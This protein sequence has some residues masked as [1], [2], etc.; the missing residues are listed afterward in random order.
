LESDPYQTNRSQTVTI[1]RSTPVNITVERAPF[2]CEGNIKNAKVIDFAGG[3]ALRIECER[4]GTWLL[5]E[6]SAANRG[7]RFAVFSRFITMPER[8][9]NAGR[10]LAAPLITRHISDGV[11][12][13]TPDATRQEAESI[14]H[15]LSSIGSQLEKD[16][17]Y[18]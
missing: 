11:F 9:L 2:L 4:Q 7:K 1:G 16:A 17:K 3:F 13:F 15:G 5:E 8:K 14:A 6:Y 12:I 18:W 10:W